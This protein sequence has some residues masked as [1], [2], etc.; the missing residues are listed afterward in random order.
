MYFQSILNY[1][2][3]EEYLKGLKILQNSC[4]IVE[5]FITLGTEENINTELKISEDS[6]ARQK[7]TLKVKTNSL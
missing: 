3:H 1:F 5:I 6:S 4:D 2:K 7:Y